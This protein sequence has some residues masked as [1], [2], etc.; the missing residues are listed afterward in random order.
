[1]CPRAPMDTDGIQRGTFQFI[2]QK[3]FILPGGQQ[4]IPSNTAVMTAVHKTL[5]RRV[6]RLFSCGEAVV[7][8]GSVCVTGYDGTTGG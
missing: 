5:I 1:M 6:C 4:H 8:K 2:W 7:G 3:N